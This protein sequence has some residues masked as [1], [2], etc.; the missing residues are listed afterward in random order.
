[1]TLMKKTLKNKFSG[2][3]QTDVPSYSE[4]PK[5]VTAYFEKP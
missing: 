3:N 5:Y 1:M 4:A 2:R